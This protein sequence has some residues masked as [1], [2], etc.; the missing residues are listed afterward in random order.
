MWREHGESALTWRPEMKTQ[1]FRVHLATIDD[2]SEYDLNSY[3]CGDYLIVH[4]NVLMKQRE[5]VAQ[6]FFFFW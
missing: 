1:Q 5:K 3:P 4:E 6:V 2:D